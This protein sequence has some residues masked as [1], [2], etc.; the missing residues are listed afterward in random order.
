MAR[1]ITKMFVSQICTSLEVSFRTVSS[2]HPGLDPHKVE[3]KYPG[4]QLDG[5]YMLR[6]F[7]D[8]DDPRAMGMFGNPHTIEEMTDAQAEER[9]YQ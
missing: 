9:F 8:P 2:I 1:R 6:P 5:D 3:T 4:V 7:V